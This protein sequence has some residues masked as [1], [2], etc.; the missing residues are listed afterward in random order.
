MA[1]V[2]LNAC[3]LSVRGRLGDCVFRE[4][5]GR[6][7]VSTRPRP[8]PTEPT[9]RQYAQQSKF[10]QAH[11]Y[12]RGALAIPA[13]REF[14]ETAG[15]TA[16]KS[17]FAIAFRDFFQAPEVARIDLTRYRGRRG[18][19]IHV[20]ARDDTGVVSVQ[21]SLRR[22]DGTLLES[23][24]AQRADEESWTYVATADAPPSQT[25]SIEA[26]AYDRPNNQGSGVASYP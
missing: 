17:A 13:L 25:L 16:N 12:V 21:V 18:D 9:A 26:T 20:I 22:A 4:R 7:F 15:R 23:G 2:T 6:T 24:P 8:S 19:P 10:R 5:N 3:L 14:Y 11:A 1:K